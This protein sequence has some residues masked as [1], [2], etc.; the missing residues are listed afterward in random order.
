M[1]YIAIPEWS[2]SQIISAISSNEVERVAAAL[3][4]AGTEHG[5]T[6]WAERLLSEFC[7]DN[8]TELRW[9][10]AYGFMMVALAHNR[11]G[12]QPTRSVTR[13]ALKALLKDSDES[14][15]DVAQ[16]AASACNR[17]FKWRIRLNEGDNSRQGRKRPRAR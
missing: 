5:T 13:V 17:F 4:S 15:R 12:S 9:A 6:K 14:V 10:A 8:R 1:K 16:S 11:R 7:T 3:K 2:R